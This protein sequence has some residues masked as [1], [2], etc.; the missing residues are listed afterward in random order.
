[1]LASVCEC[2][3]DCVLG[4]VCESDLCVYFAKLM[5]NLTLSLKLPACAL[6]SMCQTGPK[7]K[8]ARRRTRR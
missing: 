6:L 3:C 2:V 1:M 5:S 4:G 8:L 7:S